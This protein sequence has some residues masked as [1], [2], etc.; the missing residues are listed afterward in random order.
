[1]KFYETKA[2]STILF[3]LSLIVVVAFCIF[4]TVYVFMHNSP[5]VIFPTETENY[6]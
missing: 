5:S 6:R 2:G 1:M 3:F 4:L